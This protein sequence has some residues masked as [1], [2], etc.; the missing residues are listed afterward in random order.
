MAGTEGTAIQLFWLLVDWPTTVRIWSKASFPFRSFSFQNE[1]H[2]DLFALTFGL[3]RLLLIP[4]AQLKVCPLAGENVLQ[5][6]RH[7]SKHDKYNALYSR[8]VS[9][10]KVQMSQMLS[11][12]GTIP[13]PVLA[14]KAHARSMSFT[15]LP[16]LPCLFQALSC[17][18]SLGIREAPGGQVL[19]KAST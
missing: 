4:S 8:Q 19:S 2:G 14:N 6:G 11:C 16:G 15:G 13:H 5:V 1:P 10:S 9:G 12:G 17:L 7:A 18:S 3:A